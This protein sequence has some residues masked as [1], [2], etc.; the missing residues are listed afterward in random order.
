MTQVVLHG[1]LR[2]EFGESFEGDVHSITE[3]VRFL[4]GNMPDIRE[5]LRSGAWHIKRVY[6]GMVLDVGED[7]LTFEMRDA[8][9]HIYPAVEGSGGTAKT[10]IGFTLMVAS[11][12]LPA[13]LGML[14][15]S[16]GASLAV[17]G[18]AMLLSPGRKGNATQGSTGSTTQLAVEGDA[19]P[20]VF[21]R[22]MAIPRL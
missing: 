7:M 15:F 16:I 9:I 6:Q 21:G 8:P 19:I 5:V 12:F 18:I 14:A 20:C 1:Y 4:C 10:I 13:P 2:E 22:F 11:F 3:A 17:S